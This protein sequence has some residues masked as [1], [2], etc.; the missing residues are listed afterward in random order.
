MPGWAWIAIAAAL[1][2]VVAVVAA[3]TMQRKQRRR[4]EELRRRFGDEYD[5]ALESSGGRRKGEAELERRLEQ[6]RALQ[7][8][9]VRRSERSEC[10]VR[11]RDIEA[12]FD[13]TPLPAIARADALV[14]TVLADCGYPME[15]GFDQRA[16]LLSV[17]HPDAVEHYRRAHATF[18]RADEGGLSRED[19]YE[20]LQ[21][22]RALLDEVVGGGQP[23]EHA[24]GDEAAPTPGFSS[25]GGRRDSS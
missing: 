16:A 6:R 1:I 24:P 20:S 15:E 8:A 17:D 12:Q 18:R 4:T 2:V 23:P 22:Y 11:W 19:L 3:A 25:G 9:S 14:T 10:E 13:E 5:R 21:H 7:I